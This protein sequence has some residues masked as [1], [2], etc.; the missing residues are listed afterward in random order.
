VLIFRLKLG[1]VRLV[2]TWEDLGFALLCSMMPFV[3]ELHFPLRIQS[4]RWAVLSFV[5]SH[6]LPVSCLAP[7]TRRC[8]C[9]V[10]A[11]CSSCFEVELLL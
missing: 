6:A 8:F 3:T 1:I 2:I 4:L 5:G 11:S 7:G 9:A 10:T